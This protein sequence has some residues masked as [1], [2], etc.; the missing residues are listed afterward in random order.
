MHWTYD[1]YMLAKSTGGAMVKA[2][3]DSWYFITADYVF[4]QQMAGETSKF[5]KA[6]G[7]KVLGDARYPFPGHHRLLV[8]PAAGAG[9]GRQGAWPGQRRVGHHQLHQA[10]RRSSGWAAR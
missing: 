7:G 8:L 2:G 6:A 10:G 9:F 3:G 5:V 1:V 4:G